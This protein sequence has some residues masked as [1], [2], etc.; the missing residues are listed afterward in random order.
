MIKKW[1]FAKFSLGDIHR[2]HS[3]H[4][5]LFCVFFP[6]KYWGN[7]STGNASFD[8]DNFHQYSFRFYWIYFLIKFNRKSQNTR[9]RFEFRPAGFYAIRDYNNFD[10]IEL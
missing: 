1:Q 3:N 7:V 2:M 8:C 5:F 4:I 9:L 10:G 6:V